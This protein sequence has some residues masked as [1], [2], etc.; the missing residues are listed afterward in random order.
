MDVIMKSNI[1]NSW[2]I[3]IKEMKFVDNLLNKENVNLSLSLA[4]QPDSHMIKKFKKKTLN[5]KIKINK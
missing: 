3:L 5:Y 4:E 2:E 1:E